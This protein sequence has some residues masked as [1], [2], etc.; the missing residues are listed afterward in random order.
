MVDSFGTY[1]S[2]LRLTVWNAF[3]PDTDTELII[4]W[5]LVWERSAN[6]AFRF[7]PALTSAAKVRSINLKKWGTPGRSR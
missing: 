1:A 4:E 7:L 5:K 2:D 3:L 6:G